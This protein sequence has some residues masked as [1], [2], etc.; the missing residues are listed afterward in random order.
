MLETATPS[1]ASAPHQHVLNIVMGFWQSRCLAVATEL[2]LAELLK[3]GPLPVDTL[4]SKTQTDSLSLFRLMRALE[5]IGVFKQASPR[6]FANTPA[7]ECLRRSAPASQWAVVLTI[8]SVGH[9]QYEAW[10]GLKDAVRTGKTAFDEI[11]AC[12]DWEWLERNPK[13][14]EVFNETMTGLSAAIT[15][16]ISAAYDW[17]RFP[18]IGDIGGGIGTQLVA[19]LNQYPSCRG[20]LFEKP[21]V[22]EQVIPHSRVER[23]SG[24]FFKGIPVTADAYI[25]RWVIHDWADSEAIAILKNVRQ[26]MKPDSRVMLIEEIVPDPPK[27]TLGMW[28]DPHMLIM[29]GGRE[30]TAAE[31]DA[32][33]SNAGLELEQIVPTPSAHS[34]IVGR[35]QRD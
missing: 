23:V 16:A 3:D 7:S 31:Y 1:A 8:L 4:A 12:S 30:R 20:I 28:L 33:Y 10:A 27:P 32:L 14:W 5:S 35:L 26:A 15:P 17:T 34:I 6:V 25:L 22:I 21:S 11:F 2:D 9:G 24:D 18:V 29:H 19:I 13:V